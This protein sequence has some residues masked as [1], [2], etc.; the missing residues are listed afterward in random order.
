MVEVYVPDLSG[1]MRVPLSCDQ[2]L[3]AC[4]N[5]SHGKLGADLV[6]GL[7]VVAFVV[8]LFAG[9]LLCRKK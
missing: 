9:W 6:I 5:Y 3:I 2:K 7:M 1:V 4:I 8:G